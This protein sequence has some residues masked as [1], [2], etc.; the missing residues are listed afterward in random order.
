MNYFMI[1]PRSMTQA[2]KARLHLAKHGIKCTV[3]R[4][5]GRGGCGFA[6]KIFGEKSAVC[7]LLEQI[8]ISCDIPR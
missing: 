3:E 5:T 2:E 6:I 8:G 4:T 7:P 1:K